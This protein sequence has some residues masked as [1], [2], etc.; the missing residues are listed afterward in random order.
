MDAV[1]K[2][3]ELAGRVK[4]LEANLEKE[5][6]AK[7]NAPIVGNRTDSIE[8][9]NMRTFGC[10]S[11]KQLIETD[12]C[13]AKFRHIPETTKMEVIQLKQT[14]DTARAIAVMFHGGKPDKIGRTFN[15]DKISNLKNELEASA[16]GREVMIPMCKAYTTGGNADW[17]NTI[18]A[19]SYLSEFELERKVVGL[20][21][22]VP[23]QSDP[24]NHPT[25]DGTT[26]ARII[27][28]NSTMTDAT[29]ATGQLTFTSTKMGQFAIVPEEMNEDSAPSILPVI[30]DDVVQAQERACEQAVVNGNAADTVAIPA[31]SAR[32]AWDGLRKLGTDNS[33]N[34]GT[35]DF[36]GTLD[37]AG[38]KAMKKQGGKFTVNPMALA[39]IASPSAYHQLTGLEIF[40]T[41]EK[42]GNSLFTNMT[43]VLGVALGIPVIISEYVPETMDAAGV[44]DGVGAFTGLL[45]VNRQ[46]FYIG[47]R[48]PIRVRV[49]ADLPQNDRWLMSSYCR[50]DFQAR[51]Q[52]VNE[53][54]VINGFN[55]SS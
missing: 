4:E 42:F 23:M 38:I 10:T 26:E 25:Q 9:K 27:A 33:A 11:L 47:T 44:D 24:Y 32:N 22:D 52:G 41:A 54:S 8:Q 15:E 18:T 43:G 37:E 45:L 46:R 55:I 1:K 34:G 40:S 51:V 5:K 14:I 36:S 28:E 19:S 21:R 29:F 3:E 20:F 2:A 53:T 16:Y 48:R 13:D 12:V 49:I 39:W 31:D 30:R 17:I 50:K 35:Y 7:V 6:L